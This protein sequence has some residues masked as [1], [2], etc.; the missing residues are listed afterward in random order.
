MEMKTTKHSKTIAIRIQFRRYAL[1]PSR[2]V[3]K[4]KTVNYSKEKIAVLMKLTKTKIAL[5][6]QQ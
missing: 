5:S 4:R 2:Q 3:M 6:K 1:K